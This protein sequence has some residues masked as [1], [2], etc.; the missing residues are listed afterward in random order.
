MVSA[1]VTA[2][3]SAAFLARCL[4]S[5]REA[6]AA[7]GQPTEVIVI[8]N[9]ST[10]GGPEMVGREFPEACLVRNA[11]N[12][13]HVAAVNQGILAAAGEFVLLADADVVLGHEALRALM[14]EMRQRPDVWVAAPRMRDPDGHP[15]LTARRA[16]GAVN[17]LFGRQTLLSR[18]FPGNRFTR[19]YLREA[20][21]QRRE[22]YLVDWVSSACLLFRREIAVRVGPWDEGFAGYWADADW[23]LR[24]GEA[25]GRVA[26]V[27]RA[28]AVHHEQNRRGR[29]KGARRIVMF[30]RGAYR[31][32]AKNDTRG[33]LDPRRPLAALALAARAC[34]QMAIDPLLPR[35]LAPPVRRRLPDAAG[36]K[37]A[38]IE[39][40]VS[41]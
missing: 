33:W 15:Q 2:C 40:D 19:A 41:A 22:P 39:G 14:E 37:S 34:A 8:D 18:W 21:A 27:P 36:L 3:N 25:G 26:C 30:H 31:L 38:G 5:L 24:V 6:C 32:Y 16:P 17:G 20:D 9:A 35:S 7:L 23:C 28:E 13:G 11:C 29:R 12:R 1:V 4:R 10:D